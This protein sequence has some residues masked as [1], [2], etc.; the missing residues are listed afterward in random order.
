[1]ADKQAKEVVYTHAQ[2]ED[3]Y[4]NAVKVLINNLESPEIVYP[5]HERCVIKNYLYTY[6]HAC[7]RKMCERYLIHYQAMDRM[8]ATVQSKFMAAMAMKLTAGFKELPT[9]HSDEPLKNKIANT[10]TTPTSIKKTCPTCTNDTSIVEYNHQQI[11]CQ[12]FQTT[13]LN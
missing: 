2:G 6:D 3:G 7:L 9:L 12:K 5:H 1:M 13:S 4:K 10:K 8:E 11:P